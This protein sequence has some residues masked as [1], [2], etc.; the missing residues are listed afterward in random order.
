[1][2]KI[3]ILHKYQSDSDIFF[4]RYILLYRICF[5][6]LSVGFNS[7]SVVLLEDFV[8]SCFGLQPNERCSTILVKSIIIFLGLFALAF[9]FFIETLGGILVVGLQ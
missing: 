2:I 3:V 9:V 6:S 5:S 7:T 4:N 1:M 8:K